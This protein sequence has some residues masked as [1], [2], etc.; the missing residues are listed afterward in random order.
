MQSLEVVV[1]TCNAEPPPRSKSTRRRS[2]NT[3]GWDDAMEQGIEHEEEEEDEEEEECCDS[4]DSATS[5]ASP[6]PHL[7]AIESSDVAPPE[8]ASPALTSIEEPPSPPSV[9][10][11]ESFYDGPMLGS[12][13]LP[14]HAN[15]GGSSASTAESL[16]AAA[17]APVAATTSPVLTQAPGGQPAVAACRSQLRMRARSTS[18]L[19]PAAIATVA[20]A[21]RGCSIAAVGGVSA[22]GS[23]RG[24][25]QSEVPANRVRMRCSSRTRPA[26]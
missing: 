7:V 21:R 12:E 10:R 19:A 5:C 18:P 11:I 26:F 2:D 16:P 24:R 1:T 15:A 14:A 6:S 3:A 22:G 9:E 25:A 17:R 8:P 13:A 23:S 4:T 20:A